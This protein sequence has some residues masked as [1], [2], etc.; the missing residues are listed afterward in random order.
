MTRSFDIINV[1]PE[2]SAQTIIVTNV[3]NPKYPVTI[4]PGRSSR[5]SVH[6]GNVAVVVGK[7]G[8]HH[9]THPELGER[10]LV[11]QGG[12]SSIDSGQHGDEEFYIWNGEQALNLSTMSRDDLQKLVL[13]MSE[14]MPDDEEAEFLK[15][16][17]AGAQGTDGLVAVDQT[18]APVEG[19][20]AP[21][22]IDPSMVAGQ[23]MNQGLSTEVQTD[24]NSNA[25]TPVNAAG[26]VK[27]S[28]P[29]AVLPGSEQAAKE[30]QAI[31]AD[32]KA[33]DN[34]AGALDPQSAADL[35]PK[36]ET[37]GV[38]GAPDVPTG[39]EGKPF[40]EPQRE[41][42]KPFDKRTKSDI[43]DYLNDEGVQHDDGLF[44]PQL[45][46]IAIDHDRSKLTSL[47]KPQLIEEAKR[48][49][50]DVDESQTK[51]QILEAIAG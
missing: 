3:D 8:L 12:A 30:R 51:A 39:G 49:G 17:R 38:P 43:E 11:H 37:D 47:T 25:P 16:R 23:A 15:S 26:D 9:M 4:E 20:H 40:E 27:L 41:D 13:D 10:E 44:K 45:V 42:W 19:G 34:E 18:G 22:A 33:K 46:D 21:R 28:D 1:M 2:D 35:L 24:Q 14:R 48:R 29:N 31:D 6:D 50:V 7:T 5:F 32:Q 36:T